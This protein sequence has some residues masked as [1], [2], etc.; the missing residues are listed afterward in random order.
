MAEYRAD[1]EA[2]GDGDGALPRFSPSYPGYP[3]PPEF[4][5]TLRR[6]DL[7][8][9]A[10][11]ERAGSELGDSVVVVDGMVVPLAHEPDVTTQ[12]GRSGA[13]RGL[14][15]WLSR[16]LAPV[17]AL[18]AAMWKF[19]LSLKVLFALKF[20]L[21]SVTFI[22]SA[23]L[24]GWAFGSWRFGLGLVLLLLLHELGHVLLLR[25]KGVPASVPIFVPFLGAFVGMR[26]LPHHVADEAEIGIAGPIAGG[27]AAAACLPLYY[28]THQ[29]LYLSLFYIGCFLNLFNLVPISPLDGGRVVAA[30]SP[31]LWLVGLALLVGSLFWSFNFVVLLIILIAA[32]TAWGR[33]RAYRS[34]SAMSAEY[35]SVPLA[36]RVVIGLLY[37][38]TAIALVVGLVT[39]QSLL[40]V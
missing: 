34:A 8:A 2:D 26:R 11:D 23:V 22:V 13:R 21:S 12:A 38:G 7:A 31:R 39:A 27:L 6:E 33:W 40:G 17:L 1:R 5:E 18:L 35:Y 24:Y 29:N 30:L 19:L 14:R 4:Y 9:L 25:L 20:A 32:P 36:L 10:Q 16:V 37:F 3:P 28:H 15:G